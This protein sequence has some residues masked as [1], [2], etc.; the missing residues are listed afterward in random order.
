MTV[1]I[2][3]IDRERLSDYDQIPIAF[4]VR[5]IYEVTDDQTLIERPIHPPYVKDYDQLEAERSWSNMDITRWGIFLA[6]DESR[7]SQPLGGAMVAMP[8]CALWDLR[9]AP[10]CRRSGS[11]RMLLKHAVDWARQQGNAKRLSIE[12][13]NTNV[14]ACRF[15]AAMGA[16]L[17]DI[18]RKAYQDV[19]QVKEEIRLNWYIDFEA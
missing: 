17:G 18:D 9:V 14:A 19:E 8:E 11:G 5:S 1:R 3:Q 13:Q 15:Y 10:S 4:E 12:T 6:F 7:P 2:V 16:K